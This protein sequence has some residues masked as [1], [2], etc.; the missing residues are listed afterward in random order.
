MLNRLTDIRLRERFHY[1]PSTGY[2]VRLFSG[3]GNTGPAG[4]NAGCKNSMGY[5]RISIDGVSYLS[6]RLA[7]LYVYGEWPKDEIDHINGDQAD[8]RIANLRLASRA[9]NSQNKRVPRHNTS[10]FKGVSINR[11]SGKWVAM[12]QVASKQMYI[13]RFNTKE[14]A[15]AAYCTAAAKFFGEF[16][17]A[18]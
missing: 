11:K 14:E 10:G 18:A 8:N 12:I 2:F 15:H 7:W 5:F 1:N 6:H 3:R 13:G 4:S 16:A 17:R 9:Q